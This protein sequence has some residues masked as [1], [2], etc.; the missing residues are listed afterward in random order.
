MRGPGALGGSTD[1][2]R[3]R[4]GAGTEGET[5]RSWG[6]LAGTPAWFLFCTPRIPTPSSQPLLQTFLPLK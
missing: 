4:R 6:D 2:R 5:S 1:S 3:Y